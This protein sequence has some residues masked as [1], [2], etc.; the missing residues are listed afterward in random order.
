MEYKI[1]S[2]YLVIFEEYTRY[3]LKDTIIMK[4]EREKT[5][6]LILNSNRRMKIKYQRLFM[7]LTRR[8]SKFNE[9]CSLTVNKVSAIDRRQQKFK[10]FMTNKLK[11]D[12]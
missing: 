1:F 10:R 9:L 5:I 8:T 11:N 6:K 3:K 2:D 7:Q 4:A 12:M